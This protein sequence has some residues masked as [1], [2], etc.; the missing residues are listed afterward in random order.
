[1]QRALM[2]Y[3]LPSNFAAI[4][5]ALKACGREDLIGYG[6]E[7]LVPPAKAQANRQNRR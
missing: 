6:R 1:M 7:H 3:Y 2:Q 4:R 5:K